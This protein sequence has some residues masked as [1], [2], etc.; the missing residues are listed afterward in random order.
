MKN[1]NL[2]KLIKGT[3]ALALVSSLLIACGKKEDNSN[4][5]NA[6]TQNCANC[7]GLGI[8]GFPF[9]TAQTQAYSQLGW[10]YSSAMTLSWSFSGQNISGQST[11][12]YNQYASP[13][14]NYV[15]KVSVAGKVRVLSQIGNSQNGSN[16]FCPV[17][18]VGEYNLTTQS[19][20]QWAN[21]QI[22]GLRLLVTGP[23]TMTITLN[24]AQAYEYS[25]GY[26]YSSGSRVY[27][28][29]I[30]EQVNGYYCQGLQFQLN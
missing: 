19:V 3:M 17:I 27:G 25:Y 2:T 30:V 24:Q 1:V 21:G 6:Y 16:Y 15:G 22:S 29:M 9:F 11:Q 23:V 5:I 12:N 28:N 20:G 4:Q 14:M 18:P 13:A 7:E 26:Q 8:T 10:S